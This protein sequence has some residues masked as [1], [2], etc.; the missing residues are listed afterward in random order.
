[1]E[2]TLDGLRMEMV[3]D[4][5]REVEDRAIDLPDFNN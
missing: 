2:S 3:E 5:T 1:M 4:G